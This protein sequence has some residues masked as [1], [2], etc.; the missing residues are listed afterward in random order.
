VT[1]ARGA[2]HARAL[3]TT[4][5]VASVLLAG[6]DALGFTHRCRLGD[7]HVVQLTTAKEID[8][9]ALQAAAG[10][11]V[12]LWSEPSG[13]H[14]RRLDLAGRPAGAAVVLGDRCAGG[15]AV[16]SLAQGALVVACS[17][18]PHGEALG[19][20]RVTLI[21]SKLRVV[22]SSELARVGAQSEG[23]DVGLF[24]KRIELA[25][26]DG[27][28]EVQRVWRASLAADGTAIDAPR[29]VSEAAHVASA[30]A[31]GTGDGAIVVTWSERF[32]DGDVL[33]T[34]VVRWDSR[35]GVQTLVGRAHIAAMPQLVT[36]GDQLV[37]AVRD[38]PRDAKIGLYL[39]FVG[40]AAVRQAELVRVGRADGVG[41]PALEPCMGGLVSATPRTYGGDYFIGFN[42]LD[43]ELRR[44]RGEQQFYEDSHAFTQVAV[45]CVDSHALLLIAE[46]PQL[47]RETAALRALPYVC[48]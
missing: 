41:R 34:T 20:V 44:T 3:V 45:T 39:A 38:R 12:A 48:D 37:L 17:E 14:A 24:G 30:P 7:E 25:W 40:A 6:C 23:I 21:D 11:A 42:W 8:A 33:R 10:G 1:G 15:L 4:V 19:A 46:F 29:P 9:I 35:V 22:R 36:L 27:S 32:M 13:T 5:H 26:H 2:V 31:I 18:R 43:G 47:H 28:A 16:A